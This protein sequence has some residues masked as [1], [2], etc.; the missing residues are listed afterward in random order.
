MVA[1]RKSLRNRFLIVLNP[2]AGV[3]GNRVMP[4]VVATLEEAGAKVTVVRPTSGL[5]ARRRARDAAKGS[6]YDAIV[7]A[8]GDGTIR[9]VAAG[10]AGTEVPI[11][12][13]PIG[14]GNVLAREIGLRLRVQ[15]IAH[16]LLAGTVMELQVGRANHE[17]FLLMAGAG[18]DARVS[19]AVDRR[20]QRRV[21]KLAYLVP[22]A[23]AL[24]QPLDELDVMIDGNAYRGNW[25]VVAIARYYGGSF[26]LAPKTTIFAAGLCTVLFQA[27]SRGA[28]ASQLTALACGRLATRRDV[29]TVPCERVRIASK[30]QIPTQI[31]GDP[32]DCTPLEV[33]ITEQRIGIIVDR[34]H[35]PPGASRHG[36]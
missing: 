19:A 23:R 36:R 9:E 33:E 1:L 21:G 2:V 25:V 27:R 26:V 4:E 3:A 30:V 32:F 10:I 5:E 35:L 13:V 31:D 34:A 8:G 20:V 29:F 12:V 17:P 11:G 15:E 18:F 22:T 24:L 14:T 6:G 28:R 7:A 16:T